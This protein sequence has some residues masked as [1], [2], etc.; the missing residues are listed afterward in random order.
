LNAQTIGS[1]YTH[2]N[3][4][5]SWK[6]SLEL[7]LPRE[8]WGQIADDLRKIPNLSDDEKRTLRLFQAAMKRWQSGIEDVS[9]RTFENLEQEP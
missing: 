7:F 1:Y 9:P 4:W 8:K 3:G 5:L 6:S 2:D